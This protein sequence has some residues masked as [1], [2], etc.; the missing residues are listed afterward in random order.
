MHPETW[1]VNIDV[2]NHFGYA[3][4][5]A[6]P[7]FL[8]E[9]HRSGWDNFL[10]GTADAVFS[11]IVVP[12]TNDLASSV[13]RQAVLPG[14]I[15]VMVVHSEAQ[16]NGQSASGS[17]ASAMRFLKR[18]SDVRAT[19]VVVLGAALSSDTFFSELRALDNGT[20]YLP[21]V[22]YDAEAGSDSFVKDGSTWI[23]KGSRSATIL[24]TFFFDFDAV[25]GA[26]TGVR[27]ETLS[28]DVAPAVRALDSQWY[29]DQAYLT[30]LA[31]EAAANDPVVGT[32]DYMPASAWGNTGRLCFAGG[33]TMG[34]LMADALRWRRDA[35]VG[36]TSSGQFRGSGWPAGTFRTSDIWGGIPFIDDNC[37]GTILGLTLWEVLNHSVA[38][39][40][41]PEQLLTP[42]G[43]RLL[44]LS[45]IR[46]AFNVN[47]TQSRLTKVEVLNS[48]TGLY[49]PLER[50]KLYTFTSDSYT[51][52][53]FDIFSTFLTPR[54]EGEVAIDCLPEAAQVAIPKY[55]AAI[56]GHLD[57]SLAAKTMTLEYCGGPGQ[58]TCAAAASTVMDWKQSASS[59]AGGTYWLATV[60]TCMPCSA[61]IAACPV[62]EEKT[63]MVAIIVPIVV[64]VVALV[65]A[66]GLVAHF[67][68]RGDVRDVR[69]AP[70]HA[71]LSLLFT[72]IESSTKL[73]S[74][75]PASMAVALDAHH[76]VIRQC[77]R[78]HGGYEV[79]TVGDCFMI[80]TQTADAAVTIAVEIQLALQQRRF[81][82]AIRA[83]YEADE[84]ALDEIDDD[85]EAL[86]E[87]HGLW[88]GLRVRT[89]IHT[90]EAD[91]VFDEVAKGYD[92][93]GPM[94]NAAARVEA[95]ACGGQIHATAAT[96]HALTTAQTQ[97]D[98][99][100]VA[101]GT[102]ELR[103]VP[104][105]TELYDVIP[106]SLRN[107]VFSP[108]SQRTH[109]TVTEQL[110]N[111]PSPAGSTRSFTSTR[112][113]ATGAAVGE[114]PEVE[115]FVLSVALALRM[116]KKRQRLGMA[117]AIATAWRVPSEEMAQCVT[118]EEYLACV[119]R[120]VATRVQKALEGARRPGGRPSFSHPSRSNTS[121]E[122]HSLTSV[123]LPPLTPAVKN[124]ETSVPAPSSASAGVVDSL[125][126]SLP[127][128]V[129]G[130]SAS[131]GV[132]DSVPSNASSDDV[133]LDGSAWITQPA[134]RDLVEK[135]EKIA[136]AT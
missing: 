41:A 84:A 80:A 62:A 29:V 46:I 68:L 66:V 2:F 47:L 71:P 35:D 32:S 117:R 130:S 22:Y 133:S 52:R 87:L 73:W 45:N 28:L 24:P 13:V 93:Y 120:R 79:K 72:D 101:V 37:K 14:G 136:A 91:I 105:P 83:V 123:S 48:A 121:A 77:L 17:V 114:G 74:T 50:L 118:P 11:N 31:A 82:R 116:F 56:G 127:G 43:D 92:Y 110:A 97:V 53:W 88:N 90:G 59:C 131:G 111:R 98:A 124:R 33:C 122:P 30:G 38:L 42:A 67:C 112:S 100:I 109:D 64:C 54:Y 61:G 4:Y 125:P 99:E 51:A 10:N 106:K 23:V 49:E 26:V 36:I 85:P 15:G 55:I 12:P 115:L 119:G 86:D 60:G 34:T 63:N 57:T 39:S 6:D 128:S 103:G 134:P 95:T 27:L 108:A 7:G 126:G 65:F 5:A 58:Q 8:T 81:P 113:G 96:I 76:Q 25:T 1:G 20:A 135:N 40:T 102:H 104:D 70:K 69:N 19:V 3:Y 129:P 94:V 78:A 16:V 21:D 75:C 18:R 89:G 107:R 132:V 9:E 44:Q